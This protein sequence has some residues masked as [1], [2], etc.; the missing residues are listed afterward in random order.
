MICRSL[1]KRDEKLRRQA[2]RKRNHWKKIGLA[3]LILAA[4]IGSVAD[5]NWYN[6]NHQR[7]PYVGPRPTNSQEGVLVN[8]RTSFIFHNEC[9]FVPVVVKQDKRIIPILEREG[10]AEPSGANV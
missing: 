10:T 7:Q 2:A 5:G 9:N 6:S 8:Q 1:G 4:F 3:L